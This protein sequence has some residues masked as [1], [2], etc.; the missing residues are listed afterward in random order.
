MA[1]APSPGA[2]L[3]S[4]LRDE[5]DALRCQD[6]ARAAAL[7]P[8]KQARA[9]A[10]SES[11]GQSAGAGVSKEDMRAIAELAAENRRLLAQALRVQRRMLDTILAATRESAPRAYTSRAMSVGRPAMRGSDPPAA[12]VIEQT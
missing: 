3:A 8:L 6:Y 5:N 10:L 7:L 2:Q 9:A 11:A 4:V 12:V 1:A